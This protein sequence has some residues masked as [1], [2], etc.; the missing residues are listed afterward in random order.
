MFLQVLKKSYEKLWV[1]FFG[2]LLS[3]FISLIEGRP[4]LKK[5]TYD[6]NYTKKEKDMGFCGKPQDS[7]FCIP[8]QHQ[9]LIVRMFT[10]SSNIA[11]A[12]KEWEQVK[13]QWLNKT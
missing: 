9:E 1:P 7:S 12:K 10:N 2:R 6:L 3:P 5:P 13:R 11:A 4:N 8:A